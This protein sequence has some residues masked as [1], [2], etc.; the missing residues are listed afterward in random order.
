MRPS[1][2]SHAMMRTD[3]CRL[4]VEVSVDT[5][6][7]RDGGDARRMA[8]NPATAKTGTRI[9]IIT[10]RDSS[11]TVPGCEGEARRVRL[12]C[13]SGPDVACLLYTSDAADDLLCVD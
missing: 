13:V 10:C 12:P 9:Q 11:A 1:R 6:T 5:E 8:H 4:S 2:W 3:A 7:G